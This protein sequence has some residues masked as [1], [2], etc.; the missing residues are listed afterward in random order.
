ME[1]TTKKTEEVD[2]KKKIY[3]L[4]LEG[5]IDYD[6]IRRL[7]IS[8]DKYVRLR[9]ELGAEIAKDNIENAAEKRAQAIIDFNK[10]ILE[11]MKA[12]DHLIN[13]PRISER[14]KTKRKRD[15][16]RYFKIM[17]KELAASRTDYTCKEQNKELETQ[18]KEI[19]R[20][21]KEFDRRL[22]KEPVE[23]VL[24]SWVIDQL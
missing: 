18:S 4:Q 22:D 20:R 23:R 15:R 6:I 17:L 14:E 13:N 1:G 16:S 21:T 5:V 12:W 9:K 24:E 19:V 10:H 3:Q 11:S 7:N 2:L 8:W